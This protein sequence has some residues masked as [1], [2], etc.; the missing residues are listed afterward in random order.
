VGDAITT[1]WRLRQS[2][3]LIRQGIPTPISAENLVEIARE[4]EALSMKIARLER[5]TPTRIIEVDDV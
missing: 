2:A 1:A 4:L 5:M 3:G